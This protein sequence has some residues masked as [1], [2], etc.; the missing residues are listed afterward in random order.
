M[1]KKIVV[2]KT[3][4]KDTKSKKAAKKAAPKKA[5]KK[6]VSKK[7]AKK[8]AISTETP[9]LT[10]ARKRQIKQ[11][12]QHLADVI[13]EKTDSIK[14]KVDDVHKQPLKNIKWLTESS[15]TAFSLLAG[16]NRPVNPSHVTKV[17]ISIDKL[18]CLQPIIVTQID[19]INGKRLYYI[20]D[21]QHKFNALMRLGME[22]PYVVIDIKDKQELVEAIALLNASSKSWCMQDYVTAWSCL[23]ED[24]VK[25]NQYFERYDLE[26]TYIA[27]V[28]MNGTMTSNG[29]KLSPKIKKGQFIINNEAKAVKILN[30]LT[31]VLK[32]LPRMSRFENRYTCSEY[33]KFLNSEG[34]DYNHDIFISKLQKKADSF[35]LATQEEGK[36]LE[37]FRKLK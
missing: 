9:D 18:G 19:F 35:I 37:F 20:L 6:P 21:G 31:D 16:I 2:G 24:Y 10:V 15:K 29:S 1:K 32:V 8:A 28:L 25:L 27:D 22:V 26:I 5:A 11:F 7:V 34:S 23:K 17:A 12:A 13:N 30:N 14:K 4:T 33:I 36:L 3:P